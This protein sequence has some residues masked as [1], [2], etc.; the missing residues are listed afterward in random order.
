MPLGGSPTD[1]AMKPILQG[2]S[3]SGN[4]WTLRPI[5]MGVLYSLRLRSR[6]ESNLQEV[7]KAVL[8]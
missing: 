1:T 7:L 3:E 2:V 6:R 4:V 8:P 5:P